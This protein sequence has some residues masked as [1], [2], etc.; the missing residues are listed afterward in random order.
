MKP[1]HPMTQGYLGG[2]Y[3]HL[4]RGSKK[5]CAAQHSGNSLI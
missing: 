5:N 1:P 4:K 3:E 2:K